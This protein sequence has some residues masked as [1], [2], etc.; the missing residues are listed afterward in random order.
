MSDYRDLLSL[1]THI[2]VLDRIWG[3]SESIAQYREPDW[4][5]A[6]LRRRI[7]KVQVCGNEFID[8]SVFHR[9]I[10]EQMTDVLDEIEKRRIRPESGWDLPHSLYWRSVYCV[11]Y[12]RGGLSLLP[13]YLRDRLWWATRD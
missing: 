12:L 4:L 7:R 6:N 2:R 8:E 9:D 1:H 3:Q 10:L 13:D 5:M 11:Y